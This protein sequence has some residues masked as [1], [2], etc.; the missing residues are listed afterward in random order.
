MPLYL[1]HFFIIRLFGEH[2]Q[3]RYKEGTTATEF[4]GKDRTWP[5]KVLSHL[6]RPQITWVA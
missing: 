4:C 1:V 5:E 3:V 2:I 6:S